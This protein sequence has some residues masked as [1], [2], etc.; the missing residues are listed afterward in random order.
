MKIITV[1]KQDRKSG[2]Q[3][4]FG[5][6][7][8]EPVE[9][10]SR[11]GLA[12]VLELFGGVA[13]ILGLFTRPVAFILAGEMAFAYFLMHYPRGFWPA[14]NGGEAA[15]LFSFIFLFFAA[16]GGGRFSLDGLRARRR[17]EAHM[18]AT[19]LSKEAGV[20]DFST[21]S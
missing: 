17:G 19:G 14:M 20:S 21:R 13:I 6:L 15:A 12:G 18:A 7:G 11:M 3:K 8:G 16:N 5:A 10:M 4:I 1:L 2:V 9:L